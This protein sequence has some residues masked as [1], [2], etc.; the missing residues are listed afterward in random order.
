MN[1]EQLN[2]VQVAFWYYS[3]LQ[4]ASISVD[5]DNNKVVVYFTPTIP[6]C[7]FVYMF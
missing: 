2:V 4:L 5:N 1:L 7:T 3:D 6:N